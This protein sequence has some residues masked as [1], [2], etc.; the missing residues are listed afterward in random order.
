MGDF[1]TPLSPMEKLLKQKLN[2]DTESHRG[3][4]P[5]GLIDINGTLHS[6]TKEYPFFFSMSYYHLQN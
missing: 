1:T 2:K 4:E 5:N 3:N 6:K